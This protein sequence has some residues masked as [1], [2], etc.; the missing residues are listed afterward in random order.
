MSSPLL[1]VLASVCAW[2]LAAFACGDPDVTSAAAR[3][4][5]VLLAYIDPGVAGFVIVAVLGFISSMGYLARSYIARA[6]QWL[7]GRSEVGTD[8]GADGEATV[9]GDADSEKEN[10]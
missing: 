3:D 10:C 5:E 4:V 8:D 1:L 2:P 7:F 9:D 6:K